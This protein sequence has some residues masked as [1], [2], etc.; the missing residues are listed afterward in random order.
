[1]AIKYRVGSHWPTTIIEYDSDQV[2][3]REG[4]RPS[5]RLVAM[6]QSAA[7]A[8]VLVCGLNL[9]RRHL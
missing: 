1:M 7:D 9:G 8:N 2:P 5:D 6:A 4:R 3:D